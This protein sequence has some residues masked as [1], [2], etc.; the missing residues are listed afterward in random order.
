VNKGTLYLIP[1]PLT[2]DNFSWVGQDIKNCLIE[3]KYF[4]VERAKT[5]RRFIKMMQADDKDEPSKNLA[6]L[7]QPL[8][9]GHDVGLM[10]EAGNPCIA[11]PGSLLVAMAHKNGIIIKPLVGPSS[12]LMA[13]IASGF[14]GQ[15]FAFNGYLPNKREL[16]IPR[17]KA[18]ETSMY[19][20][21]QTQI[22]METPYRNEFMLDALRQNLNGTTLLCVACDIGAT[23]Q[24]ILTKT[25]NEW[26]K[27][28]ITLYHKRPSIYII[29]KI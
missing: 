24:S 18:M 20:S 26:K 16:L 25:I 8:M 15:N 10:S 17:I 2:E 12:I 7:L 6:T 14:N 23:S 4:V 1:C 28:D 21:S 19:K 11:D 27:A 5:A 3:L 29:G 22:F 9:D 13:L